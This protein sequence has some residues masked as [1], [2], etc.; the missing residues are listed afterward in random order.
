MAKR[1]IQSPGVEIGEVDISL[2]VPTPAGTT[3]YITGYADQ[4]PIDSRLIW[5][6]KK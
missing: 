6:T 4:G 3:V 5:A 2:R 1:T